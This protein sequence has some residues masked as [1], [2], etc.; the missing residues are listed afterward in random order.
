MTCR[1]INAQPCG[2]QRSFRGTEQPSC[3][4]CPQPVCR[5][6]EGSLSLT[7]MR[8]FAIYRHISGDSIHLE[9]H[10][11]NFRSIPHRLLL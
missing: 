1:G 8:I 11:L 2:R 4:P 7:Q 5:Q 9:L 6:A 3:C 10:I